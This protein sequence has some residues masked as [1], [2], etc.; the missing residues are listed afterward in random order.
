MKLT[1]HLQLSAEVN[2]TFIYTVFIAQ[3][4]QTSTELL[5]TWCCAVAFFLVSGAALSQEVADGKINVQSACAVN[6]RY[7]HSPIRPRGLVLN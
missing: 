6:T 4:Y 7:I 5:S 2:K 1:T 3:A